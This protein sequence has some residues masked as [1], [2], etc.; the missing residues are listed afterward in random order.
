MPSIAIAV[1]D[2]FAINVASFE[3]C[4]HNWRLPTPEK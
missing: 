2:V 4:S 1:W 3:L